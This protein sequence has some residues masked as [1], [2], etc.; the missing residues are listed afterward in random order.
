[1]D[2]GIGPWRRAEDLVARG[3]L[4]A[5]GVASI[6]VLVG[7][8]GLL[9]TNAVVMFHGGI[10]MQP[11]TPAEIEALPASDVHAL[12]AVKHHPPTVSEFLFGPLWRP[13]GFGS[14]SF[15]VLAMVVGTLLTTVGAMAIAVPLGLATAAWLALE[16]T[17]RLRD[18]VKF[19]VEM[20][21]AIPSVVVGFIGIQVVGPVLGRFFDV[22]GLN[23]LNGSLLLA[24]MSLPTI[25]SLAEDAISAVPRSQIQGSL[26]L[27][28][29]RWQTLVG[30]VLPTARSGLF[31]AC[32]LGMG[33][34][35]GETMTVL[36]ATG[37]AAAMPTSLLDPVR[38]MTA[39][40]AIELGEVAQGTT[41]Y[42]SLFA[43]GMLL[44]LI[45]LAV[46]ILADW[47]ARR[48]ERWG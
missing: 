33:R 44:F 12:Q 46:N 24:I 42:H 10:E 26:A 19:G 40:I 11:L 29:D 22:P 4:V 16:A 41:H 8:F 36:M 23:A 43:V 13:E 38:T 31:A 47:F 20:L 17:G 32:M 25:V 5:C 2:R 39:T 18:L 3:V 30:V 1:M 35:I 37:N 15:G 45:T 27:G 14:A 9:A 7:I 21:A 34:A 48:Q 6:A 28:A